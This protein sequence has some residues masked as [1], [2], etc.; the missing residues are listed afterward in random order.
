MIAFPSG[1]R[2]WLATGHTDMGK[3]FGS[4]ALLVQEALK[5][6]PHAGDLC[7]FRGRRG[8]LL[9]VISLAFLD[10]A[11]VESALQ[12]QLPRGFG[13][14]RLLDL[15]VAWPKQWTRLGLEAPARP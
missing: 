13:I 9:K 10:P 15:P 11:L 7:V 14:K 5:R 6:A 1:A 3:G 2:V 12:G 4:L 8:D